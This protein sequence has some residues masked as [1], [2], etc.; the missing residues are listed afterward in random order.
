MQRIADIKN[1][2]GFAHCGKYLKLLIFRRKHPEEAGW[3]TAAEHN[4][5][6]IFEICP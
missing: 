5:W 1:R 6:A 3:H 2:A 4:L